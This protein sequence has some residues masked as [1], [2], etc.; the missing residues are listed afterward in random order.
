MGPSATSARAVERAGRSGPVGHEAGRGPVRQRRPR[1]T[2]RRLAGGAALGSGRRAASATDRPRR[3]AWR[4]PSPGRGRRGRRRCGRRRLGQDRQLVG[5][6]RRSSRWTGAVRTATS[7]AGPRAASAGGAVVAGAPAAGGGPAAARVV[8][9]SWSGRPDRQRRPPRAAARIREL[10]VLA[11]RRPAP[12]RA[13]ASTSAGR[14]AGATVGALDQRSAPR[15]GRR[16][17]PGPRPGRPCTS[18]RRPPSPGGTWARPGGTGAPPRPG[19]V[20]RSA[21]AA[22]A[23]DQRTARRRRAGPAP[24][25]VWWASTAAWASRRSGRR[26]LDGVGQ[27]GVQGAAPGAR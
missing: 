14:A 7:A 22:A 24:A 23:R 27:P 15:P 8:A 5:E 26:S 12:G 6:A 3:P 20:G 13:P 9:P 18:A 21:W 4:R 1:R 16:R 17:P 25:E 10:I 2:G 19:R 11:L